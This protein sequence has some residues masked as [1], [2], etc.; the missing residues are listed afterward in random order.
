[1]QVKEVRLLGAS[2]FVDQVPL[3]KFE[4]NHRIN[5]T[6]RVSP[7]FESLFGVSERDAVYHIPDLIFNFRRSITGIHIQIEAI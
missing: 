6:G 1:M 4:I 2:F 3:S 5:L 7:E